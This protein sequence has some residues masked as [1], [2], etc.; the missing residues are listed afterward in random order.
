MAVTTLPAFTS[1]QGQYEDL[2]EGYGGICLLCGS[3]QLVDIEADAEDHECGNCGEMTVF[4]I[5]RGADLRP[6][7]VQ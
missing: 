2:A 5:E 7:R 4:G 6:G 1:T 3:S